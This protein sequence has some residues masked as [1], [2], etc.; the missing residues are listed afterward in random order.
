MDSRTA[1]LQARHPFQAAK[2]EFSQFVPRFQ[3]PSHG[4]SRMS[5]PSASSNVALKG[6]AGHKSMVAVC[7][8]CKECKKSFD[9]RAGLQRHLY[10]FHQANETM[11]YHCSHCSKGFLHKSSYQRH[12][13]QHE[14]IYNFSCQVC[15][16]GFYNKSDLQGH[17]VSHGGQMDFTCHL[18]FKKF[19]YK[20]GLHQHIK[21][22]HPDV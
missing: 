10:N 15:Q 8:T 12:L 3:Q 2:Q 4:K 14:G 18:C 20:Q 6:I 13:K 1:W 21:A 9:S 19:A 22:T 17:L 16:K 11:P 5:K 7:F